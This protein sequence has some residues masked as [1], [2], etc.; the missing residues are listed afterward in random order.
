MVALFESKIYE[1]DNFRLD[2]KRRSIVSR[3]DGALIPLTPKAVELLIYLVQNADRILTKDELLETVWQNSFVEES[4]LSQTIFVLRKALGE[5]AKRP[6]FIL[7]IPSQGYRFIGHVVEH[8]PPDQAAQEDPQILERRG[9]ANAAAYRAFV[10]GRFFW[11]KKTGLSLK[12]AVV[13]FEEAI[14]KDPNFVQ[15]YNGLA[16]CHRLLSEYYSTSVPIEARNIPVH[17]IVID[18]KLSEAHAS[19]AYAQAFYDWD[20]AGA[21]KSFERALELNPNHATAHLRYAELLCVTGRFAE[22]LP[23]VERAIELEPESTGPQTTLAVFHYLQRQADELIAQSRR[24]IE[25]DPNSAYGHFYLGFGYEF[26]EMFIEAVEIF[27]KTAVMFGEP[28]ECADEMRES[29]VRDGMTGVWHTRLEQYA[30]RPHLKNYPPYLKSLV[31]VRIG[32]LETSIKWLNQ[33]YDQRDRGIIYAKHEPFLEPLR[34]DPRFRELI[35]KMG[36]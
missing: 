23:H 10:R 31:P 11:N 27:G 18:E 32:D 1:F 28:Q 17:G 9:T 15:A 22:A 30:T 35:G 26:K 36:L 20:W 25:M 13:Q 19:L 33:A 24:I 5:D 14:E 7:T 8:K 6:R 16:D 2:A 34:G 12:E 29:F 3:I 21:E 4:N